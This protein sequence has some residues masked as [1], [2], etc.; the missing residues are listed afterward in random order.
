M[1]GALR[2]MGLGTVAGIIGYLQRRCSEPILWSPAL[3]AGDGVVMQGAQLSVAALAALTGGWQT[4]LCYGVQ[5]VAE[6]GLWDD[7]MELPVRPDIGS[8][9]L[10]PIGAGRGIR[11]AG[12]SNCPP[13]PLLLHAAMDGLPWSG[14]DLV[15][16]AEQAAAWLLNSL[17]PSGAGTQ[18]L[19]GDH[20]R[21]AGALI[22]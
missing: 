22:L 6:D 19:P 16:P 21:T 7:A 9:R 20:L 13:S 8:L 15:T 12:P 14:G 4:Q 3:Q 10:P 1:L 2:G 17:A 11:W 18:I 5:F